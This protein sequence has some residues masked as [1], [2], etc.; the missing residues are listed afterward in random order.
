[1]HNDYTIVFLLIS[2]VQGLA[3]LPPVREW[4]IDTSSISNAGPLA[5]ALVHVLTGTIDPLYT[6]S[7]F[8][9]HHDHAV[10]N[11]EREGA[12]SPSSILRALRHYRWSIDS[13]QQAS[14]LIIYSV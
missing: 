5:T 9:Y 6:I 11:E 12:H 10:L 1:M 7:T 2:S 3:A 4:L 8:L 14:S 13:Q